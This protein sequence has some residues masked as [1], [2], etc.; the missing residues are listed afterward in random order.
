[1]GLQRSRKLRM[2]GQHMEW[3]GSFSCLK[4]HW[5]L[6]DRC[7]HLLLHLLGVATWP[8]RVGKNAK[9]EFEHLHPFGR[10]LLSKLDD[11]SRPS[12]PGLFKVTMATPSY[13]L[14]ESILGCA[15]QSLGMKMQD[16]VVPG[17]TE[18]L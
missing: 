12:V 2:L 17:N 18:P 13:E 15:L 6:H 3:A 5:Y 11:V 10:D 4:V 7:T 1:M 14:I 16:E 8:Q 9:A